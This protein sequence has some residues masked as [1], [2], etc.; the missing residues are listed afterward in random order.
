MTSRLSEP[1]VAIVEG[2]GSGSTRKQYGRCLGSVR[3]ED[4]DKDSDKGKP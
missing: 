1:T 2:Q 3:R 4:S